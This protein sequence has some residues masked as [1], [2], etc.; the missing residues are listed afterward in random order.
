MVKKEFFLTALMIII[1]LVSPSCNDDPEN[2]DI[3][4]G[5]KID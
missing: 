5:S 3:S 4:I 1:I 2:I